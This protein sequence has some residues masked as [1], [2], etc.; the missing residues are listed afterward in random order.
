ME[1]NSPEGA[2]SQLVLLVI[3][4]GF[5]RAG[6]KRRTANTEMDRAYFNSLG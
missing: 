5:T 4:L 3:I 1:D 6:F 2:E